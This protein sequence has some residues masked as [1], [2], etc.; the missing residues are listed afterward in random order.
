MAH[1]DSQFSHSC[2]VYEGDSNTGLCDVKAAFL[3]AS[4]ILLCIFTTA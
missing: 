3:E 2:I 1:G 4:N